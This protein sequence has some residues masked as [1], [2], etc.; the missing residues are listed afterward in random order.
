M[1][2][3]ASKPSIGRPVWPSRFVPM[4]TPLSA[5]HI[6]G[7]FSPPSACQNPFTVAHLLAHFRDAALPLGMILSLAA[8]DCLYAEDLP[9]ELLVS[10]VRASRHA[11]VSH[12]TC[13]LALILSLRAAEELVGAAIAM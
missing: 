12:D 10:H 5:A 9:P 7:H 13:F 6:A 4:K 2:K 1:E 3:W 8:N 11:L